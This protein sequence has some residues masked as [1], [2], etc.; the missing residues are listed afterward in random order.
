MVV[1]D[2]DAGPAG[3]EALAARVAALEAA[4]E[5]LLALL[6]DATRAEAPAVRTGRVVVPPE[7]GGAT[8]AVPADLFWALEGLRERVPAPGAVMIVGDVTLPDG[9]TAGWQLGAATDDLLADDWDGVA[10]AL[11][12]LGHPVRLRLV[13]E[14]LRGVGTAR[15][16]AELDGMGTTGQVYHHLRL[17]VSAGWLRVRGGGRYEVP[18]ERVVPLMTTVLGG[19]R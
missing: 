15:E 16:L 1:T 9:R 12:A 19:R 14:V 8:A 10:D 17:L 2:G 7:A 13:R 4:V 3:E 6:P 5:R 18:A 11:A